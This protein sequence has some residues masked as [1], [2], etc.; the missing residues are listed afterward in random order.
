MA[1]CGHCGKDTIGL[2]AKWRSFP[3]SP[4]GCPEC[5]QLSYAPPERT[6]AA[7]ALLTTL[8]PCVSLIAW[9]YTGSLWPLFAGAAML[10]AELAWNVWKFHRLPMLPTSPGA[11]AEARRAERIGLLILLFLGLAVVAAYWLHRSVAMG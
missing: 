10:V 5:G 11:I 3:S 8:V 2:F 1:S 7:E 4:A 6:G 9:L